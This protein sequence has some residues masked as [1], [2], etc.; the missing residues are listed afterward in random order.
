MKNIKIA[1]VALMVIGCS[2]VVAKDTP[3]L[4]VSFLDIGQG[5]AIYIKAPNGN[6]MLIDG[7]RDKKILTRLAEEMSFGDSA[8]NVVVAT[9][10]DADHVGGLNYVLAKY[11]VGAVFE[12]GVSAKTKTY[13]SLESTI[14]TKKIPH[15]LARAG[16]TIVLDKKNNVVATILYPD[17]EV[18][19]WETNDAS[20]VLKL[21]Y[22]TTSVLLTGDSPVSK[23]LY[24]VGKDKNILDVDVLK[25][26]HHGSRTA[27]SEAYLLATSPQIAI[28]SAGKNNSYGHPHKEV[29]DRLKKLAIPYLNTADAGTINCVSN[30]LKFSCK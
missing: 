18:T 2:F 4:K 6:D 16:N 8:I 28:I 20:I 9:H 24:L 23:E 19:K 27:S 11:T 21:T 13:E 7:G 29:I 12:P 3:K 15:L 5:D 26:G 30:A 22:G 14:A 25:L 1:L 17:T 10:P